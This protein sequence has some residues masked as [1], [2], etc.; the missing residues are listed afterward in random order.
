MAKFVELT[1]DYQK[2]MINVNA[3][4]RIIDTKDRCTVYIADHSGESQEVR[5]ITVNESYNELKCLLLREDL[6]IPVRI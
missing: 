5:G 2:M 4:Q 3:I 1:N 6:Y